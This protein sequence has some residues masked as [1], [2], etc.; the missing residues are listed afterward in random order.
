M[1]NYKKISDLTLA[2]NPTGGMFAPVVDTSEPAVSSQN[3]RVLLSS[4]GSA[5]NFTQAGTGAVARTIQ[6]KLRDVVSVK[7]FGAVG[8]GVTDD[9]AAIQAAIDAQR[10]VFIPYGIYKITSSLTLTQ[11][12]SALVGDARMPIIRYY[13][14][15]NGPAINV[16]ATPGGS[17]NQH[18]RVENLIVEARDPGTGNYWT[19]TF[20]ST[21]NLNQAGV[22]FQATAY[23]FNAVQRCI[24]RN[25]RIFNFSV[26]FWNHNTVGQRVDDLRIQVAATIA[27]GSYTKANKCIGI[28]CSGAPG[29]G[30]SPNASI[31]FR[32][33]TCGMTGYPSSAMRIGFYASGSDLRDIWVTDSEFSQGDYGVWFVGDGGPTDKYMDIHLRRIISDQS[34]IAG[35]SL[36]NLTGSASAT[37][38]DGY[39][40]LSPAATAGAAVMVDNCKGVFIG[41]G[42]QALGLALNDSNDKGI[43]IK[44]S[45]C[46]NVNGALIQNCYHGVAMSNA[47]YCSIV[48]NVISADAGYETPISGLI[49]GVQLVNTSKYNTITGN[50]ISGADSIYK[51]TT[52]INLASGCSNNVISANQ[53]DYTSVTTPLNYAET[54]NYV[55]GPTADGSTFNLRGPAAG[56]AIW[57]GGTQMLKVT[58]TNWVM[59]DMTETNGVN[60]IHIRNGT[61]P[62]GSPSLGGVLYTQGGQLR[63]KGSSGTVTIVAPA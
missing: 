44:D 20:S 31:E 48:G 40:V 33:C 50:T 25:L 6:D 5:I 54:D 46:V 8:D 47:S 39:T 2:S 51:Y 56:T 43:Y 59:K 16:T 49:N 29:G 52:G 13:N 57:A 41:G 24:A 36:K 3:K 42:Y 32:N 12:Y 10:R 62:T 11:S 19:P 53:V 15:G 61:E 14:P 22:A 34:D 23:G 26:G 63:Y 38:L 7:D 37:I 45:T 30:F 58:P 9:T 27:N 55:S 4:L 1:Q 35:I 28:Y 17:Y 21:P 18:S 60:C